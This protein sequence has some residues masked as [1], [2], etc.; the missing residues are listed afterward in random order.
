MVTATIA[1]NDPRPQKRPTLDVQQSPKRLGE[2]LMQGRELVDRKQPEDQREG[3]PVAHVGRSVA[4]AAE[5]DASAQ[6]CPHQHHQRGIQGWQALLEI[7]VQQVGGRVPEREIRQVQNDDPRRR[8]ERHQ[9]RNHEE[10]DS[11][12]P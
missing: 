11:E 5:R 9:H 4:T 6:Q 2:L 7:D 8:A 3:R 10:K 12:H 1:G